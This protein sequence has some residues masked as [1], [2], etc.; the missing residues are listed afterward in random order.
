MDYGE[1]MGNLSESR[2]AA[3]K[4]GVHVLVLTSLPNPRFELARRHAVHCWFV[5]ISLLFSAHSERLEN[6]PA[7]AYTM[8]CTSAGLR[9][10]YAA[11]F[12]LGLV[13]VPR[14][15]Q[16]SWMSLADCREDPW[17]RKPHG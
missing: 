5:S 14:C 8:V 13:A 6:S 3:Q 7:V 12:L 16:H 10:A 1:H 4:L 15:Q 2:A 9:Q 11:S 17:R